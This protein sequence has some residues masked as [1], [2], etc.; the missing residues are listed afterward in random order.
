MLRSAK[1]RMLAG[2]IGLTITLGTALTGH[3][4]SG[5]G[6]DFNRA[7]MALHQRS[8]QRGA[9]YGDPHAVRAR[10]S[11]DR[12]HQP[13]LPDGATAT[14]SVNPVR[15]VGQVPT[16]RTSILA[17]TLTNPV[18]TDPIPFTVTA[19]DGRT[20]ITVTNEA[21]KTSTRASLRPTSRPI[22]ALDMVGKKN[23]KIRGRAAAPR[24]IISKRSRPWGIRLWG[25][26]GLT[27]ADVNGRFSFMDSGA[28][29][30]QM[31]LLPIQR[32]G[33]ALSLTR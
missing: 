22:L 28:L 11:G 6:L 20:V 23:L 17:I 8:G 4:M 33:S 9:L 16:V 18:P 14:F 27:H 26:I 1:D 5:F 19:N 13:G 15:F 2:L 25:P 32:S 24:R 30:S 21:G 29:G 7:G 10:G 3:A 12:P 31:L